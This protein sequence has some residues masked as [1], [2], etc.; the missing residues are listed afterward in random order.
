MEGTKRYAKAIEN[1]YKKGTNQGEDVTGN[2]KEA[3]PNN[4]EQNGVW[5]I[6]KGIF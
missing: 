2:S 6:Y 3:Y 4:G 1:G 5:Y